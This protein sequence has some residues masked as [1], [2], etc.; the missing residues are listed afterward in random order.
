MTHT[1]TIGS[2]AQVWHGSAL[3]TS[4]GLTKSNL[5]KNKR[6]RIVSKRKH[7][8]GQRSLKFLKRAGYTA[9]KGQFR[10]FH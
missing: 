1:Q 4:G 9:K 7:K 8:C 6:G 10:L 3:K 5:M 2:K